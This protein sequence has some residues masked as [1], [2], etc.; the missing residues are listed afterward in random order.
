MLNALE[1][2]EVPNESRIEFPVTIET[3]TEN[4]RTPISFNLPLRL[5][6]STEEMNLPSETPTLSLPP[7]DFPEI[8]IEPV[9][10]IPAG[11]NLAVPQLLSYIHCPT[12]FYL[13]HCLG[14]PDTNVLVPEANHA[15]LQDLAIRSVLGQI[16]THADC[17]RD[18]GMLIKTAVKSVSDEFVEDGVALHV[19]H[20]LDS[21]LGK[22][23]LAANESCC[24]QEI[25]ALLDNHVIYGVVDRLFK[26]SDGLWQIIDYETNQ[27]DSS[28][29]E[30][31]IDFYRPKVELCVLLVHRLYPEQQVIPATIFFTSLAEAHSM[32]LIADELEHLEQ[33]WIE[34]IEVIQTGTF[35]KNRGHCPHCPYFV[36]E[37]C[38]LP[39]SE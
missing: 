3:F 10:C 20:F 31:W 1:L 29:I 25:H 32:N 35:E 18:L 34:R 5:F 14:L 9:E 7:A 8:H 27:F 17:N 36:E 26:G 21:D 13:K 37:Q 38:L 28:E 22:L 16:R 15:D 39:D 2:T 6:H 30:T 33:Q 12:K 24:E 19:K 4:S 11:E 23:A